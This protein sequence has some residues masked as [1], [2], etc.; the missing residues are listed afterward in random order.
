MEYPVTIY[1]DT[2]GQYSDAEIEN[3]QD[4]F[5]NMVE[6]LVPEDLLWQWYMECAEFDREQCLEMEPDDGWGEITKEDMVRW[7]YE[8]STADDTTSLYDWLKKHGFNWKRPDNV[9]VYKVKPE[10]HDLWCN[11]DMPNYPDILVTDE[12][13]HWLAEEWEISTKE[14]YEQIEK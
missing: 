14:L 4:M 1:K 7:V 8:E 5:S 13:I 11:G 3:S 2:T 9:K 12:D 6:I 10:F